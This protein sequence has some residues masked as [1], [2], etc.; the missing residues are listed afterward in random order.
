MLKNF[1][2]ALLC[3]PSYKLMNYVVFLAVINK[4][5]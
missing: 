1:K 3:N 2:N 4:V 5:T